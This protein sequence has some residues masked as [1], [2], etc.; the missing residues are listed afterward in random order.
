M[1]G[2]GERTPNNHVW[3]LGLGL[4][5]IASGFEVYDP[6]QSTQ[7][8]ATRQ[9]DHT[10]CSDQVVLANSFH[11]TAVVFDNHRD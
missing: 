11:V 5:V 3:V 10:S 2:G 4:G 6:G 7:A 9:T 8:V 1:T